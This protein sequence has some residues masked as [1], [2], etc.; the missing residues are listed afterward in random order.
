MNFERM[1]MRDGVTKEGAFR[2]NE[3]QKPEC[4]LAKLARE[5]NLPQ[6]RVEDLDAPIVFTVKGDI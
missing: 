6:T 1:A 5:A 2:H 3:Q 4:K